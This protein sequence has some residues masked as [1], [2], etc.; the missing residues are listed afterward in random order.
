[1]PATG[2]I[3]ARSWQEPS[4]GPCLTALAGKTGEDRSLLRI[5]WVRRPCQ[6]LYRRDGTVKRYKPESPLGITPWTQMLN[7]SSGRASQSCPPQST[8]NLLSV[9]CIYSV[10]AT[11]IAR[12]FAPNG[13]YLASSCTEQQQQQQ[14]P[15][16]SFDFRSLSCLDNQRILKPNQQSCKHTRY[17]RGNRA[18]LT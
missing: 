8:L 10:I 11:P 4:T 14:Q 7:L 18:F 12:P 15:W 13:P 5:F 1:M 17:A 3:L 6:H 9:I 16:K 2:G